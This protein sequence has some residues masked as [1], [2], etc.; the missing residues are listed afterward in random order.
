MP[1][2]LY[3]NHIADHDRLVALEFGLV[4]EG[5][6]A[7]HW[8]H[9]TPDFAWLQPDTGSCAGFKVERFSRFDADARALAEIWDTHRFCAP[10]LGLPLA[11]A[12]EI[13]TAARTFF[14]GRS[15]INRHYLDEAKA[16]TG[17]E[18]LIFWRACLQAGDTTAHYGLGTTLFELGRIQEAYR[19][20]RHYAEIASHAGWNWCWYGKAAQALGLWQEARH[21]YEIA[22]ELEEDGGEETDA[23][24]LL[25]G[26]P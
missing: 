25:A 17:E 23:R 5:Q 10:A 18:A 4:H 9:L 14:D 21:A 26:L 2:R 20:L 16:R 24:D 11:S 1:V 3:L 13:V 6:P 15:S 8:R 19:H 22:I 12:G 7:A